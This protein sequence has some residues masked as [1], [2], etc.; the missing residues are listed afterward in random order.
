MKRSTLLKKERVF[1]LV[2]ALAL[3]FVS[4]L[5][6]FYVPVFLKNQAL[7][8]EIN[9]LGSRVCTYTRLISQKDRIRAEFAKASPVPDSPAAERPDTLMAVLS[10]LE[11]LAKNSD[12]RIIDIRP[13]QQQNTSQGNRQL[14]VDLRTEGV[15]E[16]YLRFIYATENSALLLKI[17]RLQLNLKTATPLLEGQFSIIQFP[18]E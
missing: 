14:A 7:G 3:V 11:K 1:L 5:R 2:V 16:G 9:T 8:R 6:F 15:M 17:K 10:E 4:A 13:Q 18:V 12:I